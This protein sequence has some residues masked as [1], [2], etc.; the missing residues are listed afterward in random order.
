M[1]KSIFKKIRVL[2]NGNALDIIKMCDD[3]Y[4]NRAIED[5]HKR[6]N[7]SNVEMKLIGWLQMRRR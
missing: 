5:F 1:C 2:V 7:L 6:K 3:W 4:S